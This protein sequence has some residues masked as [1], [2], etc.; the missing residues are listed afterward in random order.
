MVQKFLSAIDFPFTGPNSLLLPS[1]LQAVD[2]CMISDEQD[3][4]AS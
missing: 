1:S 2:S 4:G 3:Q